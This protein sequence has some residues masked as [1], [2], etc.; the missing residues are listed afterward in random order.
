MTERGALQW[1]VEQLRAVRAPILGSV[2]NG[3][4]RRRGRYY[5]IYAAGAYGTRGTS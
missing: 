5:G 1:A 3:I 4:D 2:L